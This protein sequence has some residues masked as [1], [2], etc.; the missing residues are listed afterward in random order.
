MQK[1]FLRP[2]H[3]LQVGGSTLALAAFLIAGQAY[4]T[5]A[6]SVPQKPVSTPQHATPT[7]Q[8]P[9]PTPK[10]TAPVPKHTVKKSSQKKTPQ[11]CATPKTPTGP[12]AP[13]TKAKAH[14]IVFSERDVRAQF[15]Q[16]IAYPEQINIPAGSVINF[17]NRTNVAQT[18]MAPAQAGLMDNVIDGQE[19]QAV[20]FPNAGTFNIESVQSAQGK[21]HHASKH[22]MSLRVTV[23]PAPVSKKGCTTKSAKPSMPTKPSMP[24]KPAAI[25]SWSNN[26]VRQLNSASGWSSNEVRQLNNMSREMRPQYSLSSKVINVNANQDIVLSNR[27][28]RDMDDAMVCSA[29]AGVLPNAVRID[30]NETQLLQPQRAGVISCASSEHPNSMMMKIVVR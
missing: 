19:T 15:N 11:V 18:L 5:H 8:S 7:P 6:A 29:A 4:D 9:T 10:S 23:S 21:N 13:T 3:I 16:D 2:A 25:V 20:Q 26:E 28:R 12:T 17:V 1:P 24:A 22:R 30:A 27:S 14:T